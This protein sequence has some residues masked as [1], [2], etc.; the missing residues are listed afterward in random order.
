[1]SCVAAASRFDCSVAYL[2]ELV[3]FIHRREKY[4]DRGKLPLLEF[5]SPLLDHLCLP[6]LPPAWHLDLILIFEQ[7]NISKMLTTA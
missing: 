7:N 4:G 3:I 1:M 2:Y 5:F 6:P